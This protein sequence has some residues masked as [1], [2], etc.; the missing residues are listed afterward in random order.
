MSKEHR[1]PGRA[2]SNGAGSGLRRFPA[3]VITVLLAVLLAG[4][5]A[6]EPMGSVSEPSNSVTARQSVSHVGPEPTAMTVENGV[7]TWDLTV[8]PSVEAF[9]IDT[10]VPE[11]ARTRVGAYGSE[12]GGGR[13]V[14]FLLPGGEEV[15]VQATQVIFDALDNAQE[16][17]DQSGKVILPQGR[18][19][20]LRVNAVPVEG[21]KAGVDAYR[22][23][24]EQLDLPDTSVGELQQKIAAADSV[25][26]VDASQRVS[27]GASVPKTDGLDFGPSTSFRPND[28]PLRFTLRLN[29][30]W[31]PVPIP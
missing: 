18:L 14:R 22:D 21:A 13:P 24:L 3:A 2:T 10:D 9:G 16:M 17:T 12:S 15:R 4:C 26:P 7:E 8:P 11:G 6:A 20:H 19:F 23:V 28:E 27:V 31:D 5:V 29:G 30:A 25:D 1:E